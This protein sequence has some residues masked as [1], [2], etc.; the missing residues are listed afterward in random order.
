MTERILLAP[1][2]ALDNFFAAIGSD[3]L[4][5]IAT[6][7]TCSEAEAVADLFASFGY[8]NTAEA[9]I[10][11]HAEGD[12]CGDMHCQCDDPECIEERE[13]V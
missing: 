3:T 4:G 13:E 11:S 6:S 2:L 1:A 9:F 12:D 10:E 7:L 5:D 8:G